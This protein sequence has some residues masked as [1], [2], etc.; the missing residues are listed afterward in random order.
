MQCFEIIKSFISKEI[1][2]DEFYD[3][4]F[5]FYSTDREN[6]FDGQLVKFKGK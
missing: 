1:D 6:K 4:Y 5:Y 2:I 3:T